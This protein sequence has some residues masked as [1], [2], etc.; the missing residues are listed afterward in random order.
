MDSSAAIP[1]RVPGSYF[2]YSVEDDRRR[3]SASNDVGRAKGAG[4]SLHDFSALLRME[5]YSAELQYA[6][7]LIFDETC[8]KSTSLRRAQAKSDQA[9]IRRQRAALCN[10]STTL[11][12]ADF[13]RTGHL[14]SD[15]P[16]AF[17]DAS[18]GEPRLRP[19]SGSPFGRVSHPSAHVAEHKPYEHRTNDLVFASVDAPIAGGPQRPEVSPALIE[20]ARGHLSAI[21][22]GRQQSHDLDAFDRLRLTRRRQIANLRVPGTWS[23]PGTED[24]V[25]GGEMRST[26]GRLSGSGPLAMRLLI[27]TTFPV[28]K[29]GM[30]LDPHAVDTS[31]RYTLCC[32]SDRRCLQLAFHCSRS[33]RQNR[34]APRLCLSRTRATPRSRF[35]VARH[36]SH[37]ETSWRED[38]AFH[39]HDAGLRP[40][41]SDGGRPRPR[42]HARSDGCKLGA[43]E[44]PSGAESRAR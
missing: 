20:E 40:D 38:E 23:A 27:W 4:Y 26:V 5:H 13:L 37:S 18:D 19:S 29:I 12:A 25:L 34:H 7:L 10:P 31:K 3:G 32:C 42:R 30:A 24:V 11:I 6:A 14:G 17:D 39:A 15:W 2:G 1:L 8:G 35:D 36:E 33:S 43:V 21:A 28:S 41:R 16:T 22:R 44:L 9:A